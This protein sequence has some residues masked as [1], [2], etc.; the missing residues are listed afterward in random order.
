[1]AE[2]NRSPLS[3]VSILFQL[4]GVEKNQNLCAL[5]YDIQLWKAEKFPEDNNS[6][7]TDL[8]ILCLTRVIFLTGVSDWAKQSLNSAEVFLLPDNMP[9][10]FPVHFIFFCFLLLKKDKQ[11]HLTTTLYTSLRDH[12]SFFPQWNQ[13][14]GLAVV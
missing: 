5:N 10:G 2:T 9:H 1:M 11:M 14:S 6:L 3:S 4:F 13:P 12:T 7:R 8:F